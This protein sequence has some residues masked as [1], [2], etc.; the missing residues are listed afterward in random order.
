M[1]RQRLDRAAAGEPQ[2]TTATLAPD[3]RTVVTE[4][5]TVI[6]EVN[7][8][9]SFSASP[10]AASL[11]DAAGWRFEIE[12]SDGE[13]VLGREDSVILGNGIVVDS[14]YTTGLLRS[15][16]TLRTVEPIADEPCE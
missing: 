13:S 6:A 1:L 14:I 2:I 11:L 10:E 4:T 12:R 16:A 15:I 9:Q 8:A 3:R 5:T 7:G